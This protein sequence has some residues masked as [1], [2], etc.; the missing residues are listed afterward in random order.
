M[1]TVRLN[2]SWRI[3]CAL[4][5]FALAAS[6]KAAPLLRPPDAPV[7]GSSAAA[8][9][10]ARSAQAAQATARQAVDS[11]R[12]ASEAMQRFRDQQNTARAAAAGLP[13]SIPNG[14]SVGGLEVAPGAS[15]NPDLWSGARLPTQSLDGS[16]TE[17]VIPQTDSKAVLTWKTFNVG[18]DTNVHFDQTAGGADAP[19]W[20]ALNRVND[21]SARPSQILGSIQAE[22]QLYLINPNGIVF[23]GTSQ[24]NVNS[25]IASSLDFHGDTLAQ[26]NQRFRDGILNNPSESIR[27]A[28]V[29]GED[30]AIKHDP[31]EVFPQGDGVTVQAG[32][33]LNANGGRAMLLGHN[34]VNAGTIQATDGEVV[35]AAGRGIYLNKNYSRGF[36]TGQALSP[37]VRGITVGVDRGG[38]VENTGIISS[39]RGSINIQG[40]SILQGGVLQATTGASA[41][42]YINLTAGDGIRLA[43]PTGSISRPYPDPFYGGA[44]GDLTF[45]E[46]S[47]TQILPDLS[48]PPAVGFDQFRPSKMEVFG[49]YV[50]F[51]DN[52]TLYAPS[53]SV[54][55]DA[56]PGPVIQ[57]ADDSRIYVGSGA[58]IDVSGLRGV[59][60]PMERNSI[61]AELRANELADNPLLRD[62]ALRG[63]TVYFDAR[64]GTGLANLSGYYDLIERAVPELMTSGGSLTFNGAQIITRVGSTIDLSGGNL[65]YLPGYIRSTRLVDQFGNAVPI[66][67]ADPNVLYVGLAGD[68][69]VNHPRWGV[70]EQYSN[71]LLANHGSYNPG[72]VEGRSAGTL[73]LGGQ[74]DSFWLDPTT[75]NY[76]P[77][78]YGY[79][80]L[81]GNVEA[82][83]VVGP[84]QRTAPT[85]ATAK[86]VMR[87]W[88][89]IP[90][91]ATLNVGFS[92]FNPTSGQQNGG[93]TLVGGNIAIDQAPFLPDDFAADSRIDPSAAYNNVLPARYF[94]GRTFS[95]VNLF[96]GAVGSE[97]VAPGG[98]VTIR[99]GVTMDL[100]NYGKVNI[101][102]T[103]V[104]VEGTIRAPGGSV[105]IVATNVA[106]SLTGTTPNWNTLD[107][108]LKPQITIGP[109]GTIDLAG[110]WVNLLLNPAYRPE[111]AINGG[112]LNL[113]TSNNLTLAPGSLLD[114]SGGGRLSTDGRKVTAGEAGS[115]SLVNS[116]TVFGAINV[117]QGPRD[118]TMSLSGTLQGYG[119]QTGGSLSIATG[120]PVLVGDATPG[121]SAFVVS[122]DFFRL[123]GF[124]KYTLSGASGTTISAGTVISPE[125]Q[126]FVLLDSGRSLQTGASLFGV[127]Q[128]Q[129]FSGDF[130][131]P[132]S[133]T[134]SG[135]AV[136]AN[137]SL[138]SVPQSNWTPLF[139]ENGGA[140]VVDSGAQIRMAPRSTLRLISMSSIFV[141]GTLSAPGGLIDVRLGLAPQGVR[142]VRLGENARLLAPG[143]LKTILQNQGLFTQRSIEAA[144]QV[145]IGSFNVVGTQANAIGYL[146]TDPGS[147]IDVSGLQGP[148]DLNYAGAPLTRPT[149][150]YV[151]RLVD[152]A[153]GSITIAMGGGKLGGQL[154]L[155]PGGEHGQ[156]GSLE[157]DAPHITVTQ[158]VPTDLHVTANSPIDTS[159]PDGLTVYADR[160][161]ASG[162]DDLALKPFGST[163]NFSR[164]LV[165]DGNV[166]LSTRRSIQLGGPLIGVK[167]S[168]AGAVNLT[169]GYVIFNPLFDASDVFSDAPALA[170]DLAGS[171]TVRAGTIDVG[172]GVDF[173]CGGGA[174]CGTSGLIRT[175]F[176]DVH[177][178]SSGDIRLQ[179][180]G[181]SNG[182]ARLQA[183]GTLT[184]DAAQVYVTTATSSRAPY[185]GRDPGF[186]IQAGRSVTVVGN[187]APAPVPYS[188]GE[189]LT[190]R[191]PDITQGGVLRAP[192]GEIHLEGSQSVTLAPGSLTSTSLEGLEVIGSVARIQPDDPFP[193]L[194][195]DNVS[196]NPDLNRLPGKTVSVKAPNVTVS[197][198]ATLDVSGGGDVSAWQFVAGTGGSRNILRDPGVFAIV[199]G[200][201]NRPLPAGWQSQSLS[202]SFYTTSLPRVGDT[203][204]LAGLPG[205][206]AG[207]YTLLP[208]DYARLPGGLLVR[209]VGTGLA[210]APV[211][212]HRPDA[213][214]I[215]GGYRLVDGTAIQDAG[216]SRFLVMPQNVFAK[217]S[218]FVD[219]SFNDFVA[220][221][222]QQNG[223]LLRGGLDAGSVVLDAR[224][225]LVL[226]GV[227]RFGAAGNG[228]LGNLDISSPLIAVVGGNSPAPAGYLA[229]DANAVSRFGAGSIFIG[230]TRS[231]GLGGI[232]VTVTA[233]DVVVSNDSASALTGPEIL[234]GAQQNLTLVEGSVIDAHGRPPGN[235]NALLISNGSTSGPSPGNGAFLRLSA[236][237]RVTVTR[238][239]SDG[240]AGVLNIRGGATLHSTGSLT[241]DATNNVLLDEAASFEAAQL[242]VSSRIVSIGDVPGSVTGTILSGATLARLAN[243][244]DLLIRGSQ[245]ID[246]YGNFHLGG[247]DAAGH[248]TLGALTIDTHLLRGIGNS[249]DTASIVARSL[250][251][252]GGSA[253][254]PSGGNLNLVLETNKFQL[255]PGNIAIDGFA[256]LN[257]TTN[258]VQAS[259]SGALTTPGSMTLSTDLVTASAGSDFAVIAAGNLSLVRAGGPEQTATDFGG[260]LSL[261]ASNLNLDTTVDMPAGIFEAHA[262]DGNL[263]LGSTALLR[264]QGR[265]MDFRDSMRAAPGGVILLD[266]SGNVSAASGSQ[267]DV[268][269]DGRGGDAGRIEVT[270][271]GAATIASQ[272]KGTAARG[273]RG[274]SFSLEANS[275][276]SFAQLN[277]ALEASGMNR[278]RAIHVDNG[279]LQ[280][281]PGESVTAH[282]VLLRTD[283]GS[284][285]IAG[286]INASGDQA[287]PSGGQIRL[288]GGG[289]V[290]LAATAHLDARAAAAVPGGFSPDSGSVEIAATSASGRVNFAD[291]AVVDVSGGKQGGGAVLVRAPRQGTSDI[292][293]D[294]LGG[295]FSGA[296]ELAIV[297]MSSYDASTIDGAELN[298]AMDEARA[299]MVNAPETVAARLGTSGFEVRPGVSFNSS[300]DLA[301]GANIDLFSQKYGTA[302]APG[303]IEFIAARDINV[304][305]SVSDGFDGAGALSTARSWSYAFEAGRD[306]KLTSQTLVRT[307]TGDIRIKAGQDLVLLDNAALYTAGAKTATDTGFN[308]PGAP[309][310]LGEFPTRGGN[311]HLAAGRNMVAPIPSESTSAWLYRYG[312]TAW[313]GDPN[314]SVVA[315]QTSWSIVFAN[316]QQ[317][318]GVLGGGNI[319]IAAGGDVR[320]LSVAIPTTGQMVTPLGQV[321]QPEDVHIRGGGNLTLL[322][323]G[324]VIGGVWMLGQGSAEFTVGGSVTFDPLA[325]IPQRQNI[326]GTTPTSQPYT[327]GTLAP[328]FGLADATVTVNART[329]AEIEAAF[330]PML[331]G[332]ICRNTLCSYDASGKVTNVG[333]GSA[334]YGMTDRTAIKV[335]T[336]SGNVRYENNP[337]ASVDI[338][339][340]PNLP[341]QQN[342]LEAVMF[343]APLG[344]DPLRKTT[345]EFSRAPGTVQFAALHDDVVLVNKR[346]GTNSLTLAPTNNGTFDFLAQNAVRG[347]SGSFT[348]FQLSMLDIAA[349][350]RRGAREAFRVDGD[351][352]MELRII[353]G[354]AATN[355]DRGFT[356]T[357]IDDASPAR[358]YSM[359][360]SLPLGMRVTV[361]KA[362]SAYSGK[363]LLNGIFSAQNN[364]PDNVSSFAA[365]RDVIDLQAVVKGVGDV[366]VEA[367]RE[368]KATRSDSARIISSGDDTPDSIN[369][370]SLPTRDHNL[371]LN[372][373]KG[374]NIYLFAGKARDADFDGFTAL[375]LDP[376]NTSH[377]VRTYLPE[378]ESFMA[379]LGFSGLT[380]DQLL[381]RFQALPLQSRKAFAQQIFFTE[382]KETGLDATDPNSGR[383]Q[384]YTRGYDAI[385]RLFPSDPAGLTYSD[386]SNILLNAQ[387]VETWA[388]GNITLLAPYGRVEIGGA[389]VSS[390]AETGGVIT[391]KGGSIRIMADENVDLFSSRVFTLLGG[392]VTMWS[393]NGD[394]TAGVGAKTTVFRP[395][396]QYSLDNDGRVSL[397]VFGLQTGAGIGVLA[398]GGTGQRAESRLDLIAPRG[399]VNA[400]DAGIRV[401]GNINIAAL[402][403][404]GVENIQVTG[405]STGIPKI[406]APNIALLTE[407]DKTLAA[408]TEQLSATGQPRTKAEDL[409]SIVTVEVVGYETTDR[410][411]QETQEPTQDQ[412]RRR[413]RGQ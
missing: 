286:N 311:I 258:V 337:W 408:A 90:A 242:D 354:G 41:N 76:A 132:M 191:A 101:S 334:F 57:D 384:S 139:S 369:A 383:F 177:L 253:T 239:D 276:S 148:A 235:A 115:I 129:V 273:F 178:I 171:L 113:V 352:S 396:L 179:S 329:G 169:S 315:E 250:T 278:S 338:S 219:Y 123:G 62:S 257:A 181:Q 302:Q 267:T 343:I 25:L 400:G 215:V 371:A 385:R 161:N 105:N 344:S 36:T 83:V 348:N 283:R 264:L 309:Y 314:R 367:G 122:P 362:L 244:N 307:G 143:Y 5:L 331:Q 74:P 288:L 162:T 387:K 381:A 149:S 31:N 321:A 220:T 246:L 275:L 279:D 297:G 284:V 18:R 368:I 360:Q 163:S 287:S 110:R 168:S 118:G 272:F 202:S 158:S 349:D 56:L 359:T 20:I 166:S 106:P 111:L 266:A 233:T 7:P 134:L 198:G 152:G 2:G 265:A 247:R 322:A 346:S 388:G 186:L 336:A 293:I 13:S 212:T 96:S 91:G 268:S 306:V 78:D 145:R 248:P 340:N 64:L 50:T 291:G 274:G 183:G 37:D 99:D 138:L 22:G 325:R 376:Q 339:H 42:G 3:A 378:L 33:Q 70:T 69:M 131:Q 319:D 289:G 393:S 60:V 230:G 245:S 114:V 39:D 19:G 363:D 65:T 146:M 153:A 127:A 112:S 210:N 116:V 85:G 357:H 259:G 185:D 27:P 6:P 226:K 1:N 209:A 356:P 204:Y 51:G 21:P 295:R 231:Q 221:Q 187:G 240:T 75:P 222:S 355:N 144:G 197:S 130:A 410:P 71:P 213:S 345:A 125:V 312:D 296:R 341:T 35:L 174:G 159:S 80:V 386:R 395:P 142:A 34:V 104:D 195:S 294:H 328:L 324:N 201:G 182:K 280:L 254:T 157:F 377:V 229:V 156:G 46:G 398:A 135:P 391:R 17:V 192:L 305:A 206:A 136:N 380:T 172:Y 26:R 214:N 390:N 353:Q 270:S 411:P 207:N 92:H 404:V 9:A 190:I 53:A 108:N 218:S 211:A 407:T 102:A 251:L 401:V 10:A 97:A 164:E 304:N 256:N 327:T 121:T 225:N 8:A 107:P 228:L 237:N 24:V 332:Q 234:L 318:I 98:T 262:T 54:T 217:Y 66:E 205:L 370:Q 167:P 397:N 399:E 165:F 372:P 405:R 12:R 189:R 263:N 109:T 326:D 55:I 379:G 44:F 170:T 14:L 342:P 193:N 23:G 15:G 227:G 281:A 82:S 126:S 255:G 141:D 87:V 103:R 350:F 38:R 243:A 285:L 124:A 137:G 394:I 374:A 151:E 88:H 63:Q 196:N 232:N 155:A 375:Y 154:R 358:L 300:S 249:G 160:V 260:R 59:E 203:V 86:D 89:E 373:N 72:Y 236:G 216:Y 95:N 330:D 45:A 28:L 184:L 47:T 119:L 68:H 351:T 403:V 320:Q 79:R 269:G 382:L 188:Y 392:D 194:A 364:R 282:D 61:K 147:V 313:T 333:H 58:R 29:F 176:V 299:W 317:G 261:T 100:G 208:A 347:E 406:S 335:V 200:Y 48:S 389:A 133:L 361:P 84:N 32:A 73:T 175:G 150:P 40:K 120:K 290:T 303:Y 93:V 402:R 292:A 271:G 128:L 366:V 81:D 180:A 52:S 277:A 412:H 67:L 43:D 413:P 117:P 30:L 252:R 301:I 238:A 16:Q 409:P 224:S 223:V 199:P 308:P 310:V 49:R 241:F 4:G 140:V 298:Q 316:F 365:E 94:D 11:L 77:K 323:G 173:G